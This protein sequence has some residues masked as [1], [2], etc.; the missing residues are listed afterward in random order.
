MNKNSA[1]IILVSVYMV[2]E[3]NMMLN[4]SCSTLYSKYVLKGMHIRI[5]NF[6]QK[7]NLLASFVLFHFWLLFMILCLRN[8]SPPPN[9]CQ[10]KEFML[11]NPQGYVVGFFLEFLQCSFISEFSH[12][13]ATDNTNV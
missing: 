3:N 4:C 6:I 9:S 10:L 2:K 11:L 1:F 7:G 8:L 13:M 5:C 12:N